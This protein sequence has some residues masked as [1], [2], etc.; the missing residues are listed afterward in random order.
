MAFLRDLCAPFSVVSALKLLN[1]EDA[2]AAQRAQRKLGQQSTPKWI[3][4]C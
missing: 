3:V 4:V 2:E 1:A